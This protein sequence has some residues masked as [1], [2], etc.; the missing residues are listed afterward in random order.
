MRR[1]AAAVAILGTSVGLLGGLACGGGDTASEP[2]DDFRIDSISPSSGTI[3]TELTIQG[4]GFDAT[5]NDIGFT[6]VDNDSQNGETGFETGVPSADG[7]TLRF[8]L[9]DTL[10]VCAMSQLGSVAVCPSVGFLLPVGEINVSVYNRNGTSNTVVFNREISQTE[11]AWEAI[12][13]APDYGEMLD[14]L[15]GLVL[16]SY[17]PSIGLY[18]AGFSVSVDKSAAGELYIEL[19]TYGVDDGVL[20][21]RIPSEIAGYEVIRRDRPAPGFLP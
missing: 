4:H 2:E 8:L 16:A 13:A 15:D 7:K 12:H 19:G 20:A 3:G 6:P 10:G 5:N 1:V 11:A 18:L 9:A 21:A 14:F 17:Q